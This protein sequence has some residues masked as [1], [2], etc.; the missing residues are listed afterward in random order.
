MC[1][2]LYRVLS[3]FAIGGLVEYLYYVFVVSLFGCLAGNFC[4]WGE[5]NIGRAGGPD[6]IPLISLFRPAYIIS[7]FAGFAPW[8]TLLLVGVSIGWVSAIYS[9]GVTLLGAFVCGFTPYR[10]R[11]IIVFLSPIF[12]GWGIYQVWNF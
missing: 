3:F 1:A 7:M 2:Y 12:I 9:F 5:R 8:V 11:H 10:V 4:K 6:N